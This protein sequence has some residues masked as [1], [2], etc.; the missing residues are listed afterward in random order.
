[1]NAQPSLSV[2]V[3]VY[4][5]MPFLVAQLESLQGQQMPDV[6]FLL[7]DDG[8]SD[9]SAG[10][11]A[12]YARRDPRMRVL[13]QANG[14]PSRARNT[15][16]AAARGRY[17]AFADADD[18]VAPD[19]CSALL[20]RADADR[21]DMLF[22]NGRNFDHDPAQPGSALFARAK[23]AG[24]VTGAEWIAHCAADGE[25]LHFVWLQLC[26]ADLAKR[27]AFPEGIVH[28]DVVWTC[29]LLLAAERVGYLD[30]MLYFYRKNPV[31]LV[32]NPDPEFQARRIEGYLA[33]VTR[34][35]AMAERPGLPAA[36]AQALFE[37]AA[38]EA[39]H[40]FRL[41]RKLGSLR[42]MFSH[43]AIAADAGLPALM[44]RAARGAKQRRRA[45]KVALLG[46]VGRAF[47]AVAT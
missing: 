42:R 15:A 40:V 16:I 1:M 21:L 39:G 4:N 32:R 43:Y 44:Q 47:R 18:V 24:P 23:P 35:V 17:L 34:L 10:V 14:G 30:R 6:E 12:E 25:F 11:L 41:A 3:P 26:R 37:Q 5:A 36:T 29:E 13:Q 8:S 28:E 38:V 20:A 45:R 22:C 27:F 19:F 33:V 2:V 46:S 9:G 7:I 31:S